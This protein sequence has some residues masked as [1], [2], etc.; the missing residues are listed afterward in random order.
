MLSVENVSK[1]YNSIAVLEDINFILQEEEIV[2]L[3]GINGAGKSTLFSIIASL[4]KPTKGQILFYKKSIT[5]NLTEYRHISSFC[6]S[7]NDLDMNLTVLQNLTYN[8]LYYAIDKKQN[9]RN[10][11]KLIEQFSL[12][13]Y[14]NS[15]PYQLSLGY[16]KRAMLARSLSHNPKILLL[17]EP[18]NGLDLSARQKFTELIR[19]VKKLGTSVII[20]SHYPNELEK[21]TDRV[22][23]LHCGKLLL[24]ESMISLKQK[25]QSL[26]FV[27]SDIIKD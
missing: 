27:F 20:S 19:D 3:L 9:D 1:E 8:G 11:K 4:I 13:K 14:V 5:E 23:V 22:L 16:Q 24:H 17:D 18:I 21:I 26:N 15:Y 12:A 7:H 6:P 25:N 2:L 10:V